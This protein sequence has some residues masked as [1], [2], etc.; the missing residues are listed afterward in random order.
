MVLVEWNSTIWQRDLCSDTTYKSCFLLKNILENCNDI[1]GFSYWH[2]SDWNDDYL[3]LPNRFHGGFGL[4]TR[5]NI[6]KSAYGAFWLL[7]RAEGKIQEQGKGY[8]V[9][10]TEESIMIYLYNYCPYDILYRYRHVRD[11][12]LCNRYNVF[13]IKNNVSYY[14]TLEGMREGIYQEKIYQID[15]SEGSACDVWMRMGGPEKI[16]EI[17]RSYILAASIPKCSVAQVK[18]EKEYVVHSI[19]EPHAI[20]LIELHRI[21]N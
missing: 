7:S 13:E 1:S 14:I 6:P 2:V 10:S 15:T 18:V 11:I 4:F 21:S 5:D 19:L 12:S 20:Q 9:L 8:M 3:P 17:E 16:N